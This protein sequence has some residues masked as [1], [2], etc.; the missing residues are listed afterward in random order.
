M[1]GHWGD[2]IMSARWCLKSPASRLFASTVCSG[3]DQSIIYKTAYSLKQ[4]YLQQPKC[5]LN[6]VT[7][8]FIVLYSYL[9]MCSIVTSRE[10]LVLE[11][12]V[13]LIIIWIVLLLPQWMKTT[14]TTTSKKRKQRSKL[15][16]NI[17]MIYVYKLKTTLS[18]LIS[19]ILLTMSYWLS[20][21]QTI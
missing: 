21:R 4:P 19:R 17:N 5:D 16:N 12:F 20:F 14:T 8:L 6:T 1:A 2:V 15:N 18:D 3:S 13:N 9:C 11:Q 7:T 10:F